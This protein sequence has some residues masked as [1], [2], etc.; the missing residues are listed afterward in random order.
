MEVRLQKFISQCGIASR[1]QAEEMIRHGK[2]QIN[3][4]VA[5]L[6]Q[7]I[8]PDKDTMT[9]DGKVISISHRP[10]KV[11]L[12][13]HKPPGIV[14]TCHDPQGRRTVIDLLP[15]S[16]RLGQ[17][18]HPVGRLDADS[19]GALLLTNDGEL[20]FNLTHPRHSVSKTYHVLLKGHP[21][22]NILDK[23]R[24]GVFLDT[25]TTRAAKIKTIKKY[26]FSTKLEII[27]KEG[28]NRQIRRIAEQLGYPVLKLHRIAI[29]E[30]KLQTTKESFLSQGFYRHLRNV[31][32]SYLHSL[33]SHNPI[34]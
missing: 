15:K 31:E 33:I 8:D 17:G 4:E 16:L 21:P 24:N 5:H 19:T 29:G 23:W 27:L 3:G 18:I 7:K 2:V 9:V 30:I 25:R 22:N 34:E 12:L 14:S 28:R 13:L 1:R 6:G 10:E 32:I 11:Y 26:D 20:T